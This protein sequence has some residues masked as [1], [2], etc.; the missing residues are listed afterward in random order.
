[1]NE[2]VKGSQVSSVSCWMCA[3]R[4]TLSPVGPQTLTKPVQ[5]LVFALPLHQLQEE[6]STWTAAFREKNNRKPNLLDV[7]RTGGAAD[8]LCL[9][10]PACIGVHVAAL[11]SIASG[12]PASMCRV[13]SLASW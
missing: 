4:C 9:P 2:V 7:Q 12:R 6:L 13:L 10:L 5:T 11:H 3:L 8:C 1:M